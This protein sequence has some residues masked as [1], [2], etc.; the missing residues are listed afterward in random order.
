[1]SL[2]T[3]YSDDISDLLHQI[4]REEETMKKAAKVICDA[5]MNNKM[6]HVIGPG[7]HSNI[8]VE[9]TTFTMPASDVYVSA[10]FESKVT[11]IASPNDKSDEEFL[12]SEAARLLA[13]IAET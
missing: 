10:E 4:A 3:K 11:Y 6:V 1:M 5:Y 13:E 9:E 12:K 2:L 7:G 8:A